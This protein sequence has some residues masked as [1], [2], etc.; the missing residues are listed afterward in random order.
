MIENRF[1]SLSS[2]EKRKKINR[3]I[4]KFFNNK[5]E[6]KK[7]LEESSNIE[8]EI[9]INNI[10]VEV[11]DNNF[12]RKN[13]KRRDRLAN[14][15]FKAEKIDELF[16][17]SLSYI[18]FESLVLD[19]NFKYKNKDYIFETSRKFING[20]KENKNLYLHE[21]TSGT[22]IFKKISMIVEESIINKDYIDDRDIV[23]QIKEACSFEFNNAISIIKEKV[24]DTIDKEKKYSAFLEDCKNKGVSNKELR[25]SDKSLFRCILEGNIS[26]VINDE[27]TS[28]LNKKNVMDLAFSESIFDYT[29]LETIHTLKLS[30]LDTS[31]ISKLDSYF[32]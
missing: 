27:S 17:E 31:N 18:I 28:D 3:N 20:I 26:A 14:N 5:K 9:K 2:S 10:A 16:T 7:I 22:D 23:K 15:K 29:L 6:E 25:K 8:Q 1:K 30:N 11:K 32:K 19:K 24:I 21:G 13:K 4:E 12:T